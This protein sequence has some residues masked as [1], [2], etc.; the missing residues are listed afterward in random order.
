[1]PHIVEAPILQ[2]SR[3]Y[4]G[5]VTFRNPL[6]VPIR[7]MGRR[8]IEL[9]DALNTGSNMEITNL[10]TLK[11]RPGYTAYNSHNVSGIPLSF[12]SFK[13]SSFP[14]QVFPIAD[15]TA[16]VEY[17][18]PGS[19]A[20]T[21]VLTKTVTSQTNFCG[22]GPYLYMGNPNFSQKWD[23]PA[24]PQGV[25]NWGIAISSQ[26][27]ATGPNAVTNGANSGTG[28]WTN[29][30]NITVEDAAFA[31]NSVVGV[32]SGTVSTLGYL[33]GTNCGFAIPTTTQI[34]GIKVE[35]KGMSS[36]GGSQYRPTVAA[37]TGTAA[38]VATSLAYDNNLITSSSGIDNNK[39]QT[40]AGETWK[41]FP[42]GPGSPVSVTLNIKSA[43]QQSTGSFL[44][45]LSYSLNNGGRRVTN[46]SPLSSRPT[47]TDAIILPLGQDFTQVQVK[48]SVQ[49][50]SGNQVIHSIYEIWVDAPTAS[51]GAAASINVNLLKAGTV[52]GNTESTAPATANSFMTFGGATDLW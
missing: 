34:T 37:K 33:Q 49:W 51:T 6:V 2:I 38:Y 12:Y 19:L 11:R 10:L 22:I 7:Q 1:M 44:S 5:L 27:N 32:L 52:V 46:F 36:V 20:I 45:T 21:T 18:Q 28:T 48:A 16:D 9:Y 40:D 50:V 42:A 26:S 13:P 17:V 39:L 8:I 24:G 14:G 30:G 25:T 31:T 43:V 4:T 29:P 23:G 35:V 41:T 3:F 47:T 15:T